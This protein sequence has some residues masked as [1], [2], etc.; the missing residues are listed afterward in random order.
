[1]RQ[2]VYIADANV[3]IDLIDLGLGDLWS[4]HFRCLTSPEVFA[5]VEYV[6]EDDNAKWIKDPERLEV[7]SLTEE[8]TKHAVDLLEQHSALSYPDCTVIS[9]ALRMNLIVL[10]GD[11]PMRK[12]APKLRI[13]L[14]GMLY[15]LN[16]LVE[17]EAL[18]RSDAILACRNWQRL[19]P[20]TP[21]DKCDEY[22][23]KW[24][25]M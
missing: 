5:E 2:S 12:K 19:N 18:Q 13:R 16:V 3:I 4:K 15:I 21:T 8:D 9:F 22:C 14:H 25:E 1:M 11:G 7:R 10:S 20:R 17:L 23:R 6:D 24:R